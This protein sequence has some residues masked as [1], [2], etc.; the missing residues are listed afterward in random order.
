MT[1]IAFTRSNLDDYRLWL[2]IPGPSREMLLAQYPTRD[3]II[4]ALEYGDYVARREA[5]RL[6]GVQGDH[7]TVL[8]Y[9]LAER[10]SSWIP[11]LACHI[12]MRPP[13]EVLTTWITKLK[14][15]GD[16]SHLSGV[17]TSILPIMSLAHIDESL[18]AFFATQKPKLKSLRYRDFEYLGLSGLAPA[19]ALL[20]P[21][22]A[23]DT[24]RTYA[25][26]LAAGVDRKQCRPDTVEFMRG[27][28]QR[29]LD[30]A[31][32]SA[33]ASMIALR[34]LGQPID[35]ARVRDW[36]QQI[37]RLFSAEDV[38]RFPVADQV[39]GLRWVLF[40]AGDESQ[41][42]TMLSPYALRVRHDVAM[43]LLLRGDHDDFARWI[44]TI[45]AEH[46]GLLHPPHHVHYWPLTDHL[47]SLGHG[48]GYVL[49]SFDG[50]FLARAS[51]IPAPHGWTWK[52]MPED[53]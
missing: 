18:V 42:E 23:L 26:A 8:H 2:G 29:S 43:T 30:R 27:E 32:T 41:L 4:E 31:S 52:C 35:T 50:F 24:L 47:Q 48:H 17:I 34:R 25:Q 28:E 1:P 11:M 3:A 15:T 10:E 45:P 49:P 46:P 22:A 53:A 14:P 33:I 19:A 36:L 5:I 39:K 7:D 9:A 6:L 20:Q 12:L 51:D 44:Q 21:H 16:G 37:E 13:L 40:D 38:A